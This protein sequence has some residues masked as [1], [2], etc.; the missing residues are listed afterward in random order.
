M[1]PVTVC[2]G[3]GRTIDNDFIYCPWC[4]Y[5]RVASDDSASLEAV[6]NQLEQLQNDS[7][8]RQISEMEKQ[9]DDLVHELDTIVLSAEL[10]K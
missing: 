2:R 6:F 9:L 4:G 10:H 7:R 8:N 3:C 5:S 1:K